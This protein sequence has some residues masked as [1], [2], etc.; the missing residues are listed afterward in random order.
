MVVIMLAVAA[1]GCNKSATGPSPG[2]SSSC[3]VTLSGA[4]SGTYDCQPAVTTWT[5]IDN[6]GAFTFAVHASGTRPAISVPIA[7]DSE[8]A[9]RSYANTDPLAEAAITVTNSSGQVWQTT[10]GGGIPAAGSYSLSFTSVEYNLQA[11]GGKGYS[12]EGTL[13]ATLPAVAASGATAVVIL[14]ATF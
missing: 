11:Q 13:N 3:T 10:V 4:V 8:P 14:T 9:R 7:W 5:S 12:A 6:T 2:V 1:L